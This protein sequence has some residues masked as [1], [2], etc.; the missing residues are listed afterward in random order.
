[1]DPTT[2]ITRE[3]KN[4]INSPQNVPLSHF[5]LLSVEFIITGLVN[6]KSSA[7]SGKAG[8]SWQQI[9]S[10]ESYTLIKLNKGMKYYDHKKCVREKDDSKCSDK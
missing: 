2:K 1:M 6:V 9:V 8:Q 4:W 10:S 3:V 5:P 7:G